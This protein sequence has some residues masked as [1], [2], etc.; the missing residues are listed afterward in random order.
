MSAY[1]EQ[2]SSRLATNPMNRQRHNVTV[3]A[4]VVSPDARAVAMA[5]APVAV[6][7]AQEVVMAPVVSTC[8]IHG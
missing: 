2:V 4:E 5:V 1:L 3:A 8:S 6:K 7:V